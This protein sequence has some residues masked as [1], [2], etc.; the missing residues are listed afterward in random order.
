MAIYALGDIQGCYDELCRLLEKIEFDP[1]RDRIW[2]CGDLVN[3]GPASL[4][5]L[6]FVKSLGDSAVTVLGNHDLHLLALHYGVRKIR[7][8]DS[9]SQILKSPDREELMHWLQTRP[10]LHRDK[11]HKAVMVHA[12][13]HP[14]WSLGKARKL[15]AEIESCL[16]GNRPKELLEKMYGNGPDRWSDDLTNSK[17]ARCIINVFTRMRYLKSNGDFDFSANGSPRQYKG[18][19]PWF[20]HGLSVKPSVRILFGHWSTLQVGCYGR[21]FALDGGCV[22]GG[23][24]VALRIDDDAEEWYFVDSGTRRPIRSVS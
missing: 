16:R 23:Q 14:D 24:L 11:A 19:V 17:R 21:C 9:L 2:F 8:S 3:R 1:S 7:D 18:L 15:A 4:E 6:R 5:T 13:I 22:W 20:D 12:G 10:L